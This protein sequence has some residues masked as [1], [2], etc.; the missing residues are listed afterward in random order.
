MTPD[1][2]GVVA[3]ITTIADLTPDP[4]N[5]RL[6]NP[7]NVG[8]IERALGEVG[9][10][11]SIVIDEGGV[12]LAGNA[13]VEAAASAGIERVHVVDADGE[14]IIAVRRSGLTPAQKTALA[15]YDNRA[16][17]L[18]PG[19]DADVLAAI[20]E[21]G[22]VDLSALWREEELADVLAGIDASPPPLVTDAEPQ[23]DRAAELAA[24]W[25]TALGQ[26]WHIGA[27]TLTIGDGR[28]ADPRGRAVVFDPP[29]DA[30]IG[31][32]QSPGG[33]LA[34]C[35][36]GRAADVVGLFGSPAW[37]FVW[38][39]VSSWYTPNRPLRRGKLCLWYGDITTYNADGAHYGDAGEARDVWNTRG[40]YRFMPDPRGKH[41]ADVFVAPITVEHADGASHSKPLD[42]I[43][44][45][46]GNC[47]TGDVIDPFV[48]TGT[49]IVACEQLG[50]RCEAFEI[51]PGMAAVALDR[52]A[53]MFPSMGVTRD[54]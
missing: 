40:A 31:A 2:N 37:V 18:S 32:V 24:Q 33:V 1:G 11:R 17:E 29:W 54:N 53:T 51:D 4:R 14:T 6:H 13:T 23:I 12:I 49:S 28:A 35:D 8:L 7:R 16:A 46:I 47:T 22:D 42:W 25:G 9:A 15:L 34:F 30:G 50:R 27:H 52:V 10:A 36:G 41:L 48:G 3:G 44:L 26:T 43:R 20:A 38:D 45:L 5:A 39:C 19:W 21:A